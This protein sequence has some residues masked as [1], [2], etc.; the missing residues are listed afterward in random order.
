MPA[1]VG[2]GK[3]GSGADDG[4]FGWERRFRRKACHDSARA[5]TIFTELP[6]AWAGRKGGVSLVAAMAFEVGVAFIS[7]EKPARSKKPTEHYFPLYFEANR[8][9]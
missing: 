7:P 1:A 4:L 3:A 6:T 5:L 2:N 9:L 8:I